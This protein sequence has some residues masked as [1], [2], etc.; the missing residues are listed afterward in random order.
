MRRLAAC[1]VYTVVAFFIVTVF[2]A[3]LYA[4]PMRVY[5]AEFVNLSDSKGDDWIG[6]LI[7]DTLV[8]DL[9][10]FPELEVVSGKRPATVRGDSRFA[11]ANA[12]RRRLCEMARI[13]GADYVVGGDFSRNGEK[14]S[15]SIYFLE[16]PKEKL[17]GEL[18]FVSVLPDLYPKLADFSVLIASSLNISYSGKELASIRRLPTTSAEAMASYGEALTLPATSKERGLSLIKALSIDPNYSDALAKLGILYYETGRLIDA[19]RTF[20]K[21]TEKQPEYPHAYY[22]LALVHRAQNRLSKA[23]DTYR[24]ALRIQPKDSD[25]WNNLGATYY[26]AGMNEDAKEAFM[27][28]VKLN[29]RNVNARANLKMVGVEYAKDSEAAKDEPAI[30]SGT[31]AVERVTEIAKPVIELPQQMAHVE[32]EAQTSPPEASDDRF[33]AVSE[34]KLAVT[35]P[36]QPVEPAGPS[37]R[38]TSVTESQTK[39]ADV[40]G[41]SALACVTLGAL[42]EEKGDFEGAIESYRKAVLLD[43]YNADAQYGIG[44]VCLRLNRYEEAEAALDKARKLDPHGEQAARDLDVLVEAVVPASVETAPSDAVL[45]SNTPDSA[46]KLEP[47]PLMSPSVIV[48]AKSFDKPELTTPSGTNSKPQEEASDSSNGMWGSSPDSG[49]AHFTIGAIREEKGDLEGALRSY[50]EAV[51]LVPAN[52]DAQYN[53]GNIY[54]R[55]GDAASAIQCYSAAIEADPLFASCYNNL[56]VAYYVLGFDYLATEAWRRA[57]EADPSMES[58]KKNIEAFHTSDDPE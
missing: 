58:A 9:V 18:M 2:P 24:K 49:Y 41:D 31:A 15:V 1:A 34:E 47:K 48:R 52:A 57:L 27:Q 11:D 30:T 23:V 7:A 40:S 10:V 28:A 35:L 44:N 46:D 4:E 26:V 39:S 42:R 19:Q 21:L 33:E 20:E 13:F 22:N 17:V 6:A 50:R 5:A 38:Q 29:P 51:R 53:L 43:P 32:K 56:G 54:M 25:A 16:T 37:T 36:E 8:N 12:L 55:L 45:S 3:A 14:I